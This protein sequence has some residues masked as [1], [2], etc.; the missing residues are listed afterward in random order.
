MTRKNRTRWRLQLLALELREHQEP[1]DLKSVAEQLTL[2]SDAPA[3]ALSWCPRLPFSDGE[4]I[5][6]SE[7]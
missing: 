5:I 7:Q 3:E 4:H 6:F 1:V 2:M